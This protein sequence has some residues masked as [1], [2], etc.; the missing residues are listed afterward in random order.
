MWQ[1][2][3]DLD[4]TILDTTDLILKSFVHTFN[5]GLHRTVTHEELVMHFGRPLAAQFQLMCPDLPDPEIERLV[6]IYREHN[7]RLHDQW[8]RVVPGADRGLRALHARGFPL[9]IVTSKRE[10]LTLHGLEL[11]GLHELFHVIVHAESTTR[12]KPHPEPVELARKLLGGSAEET[13]YVGDSPY[14]MM[15]GRS[16]GVH[17]LGLVHNTFSID[18][19]QEAGAE[20]VVFDWGDVTKTLTG[21]AGVGIDAIDKI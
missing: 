11:F 16:S 18:V 7:E 4:G 20:A 10:D 3:F 9:G 21:W 12:H 14:D 2:L 1:M 13:A 8:A 5:E 17:T 15:A 6:A 19:L